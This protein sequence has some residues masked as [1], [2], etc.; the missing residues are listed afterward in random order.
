MVLCVLFTRTAL[1]SKCTKYRRDPGTAYCSGHILLNVLEGL[2]EQIDSFLVY[3]LPDP[4]V[5]LVVSCL[6]DSHFVAISGNFM[7]YCQRSIVTMLPTHSVG[8]PPFCIYLRKLK[9]SKCWITLNVHF[10]IQRMAN[11]SFCEAYSRLI[12]AALSVG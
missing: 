7:R 11:M 8:L 4:V 10:T 12:N 3:T 5:S 9:Y 2:A 6:N 1:D